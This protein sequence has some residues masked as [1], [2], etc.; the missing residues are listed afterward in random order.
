M[1]LTT[2]KAI[3]IFTLFVLS[4][5]FIIMLDFLKK[6]KVI[7]GAYQ[8]YLKHPARQL[9]GGC[10]VFFLVNSVVVLRTVSGKE[11]CFGSVKKLTETNDG[12]FVIIK[13][14][15]SQAV[16]S[17]KGEFLADFAL[18]S[19][20]F[21]NGWF[22]RVE[23][24]EVLLIDENGHNICSKLSKALVFQDGKY[25]ISVAADGDASKVGFFNADG[26]RIIFTNDHG[27]KCL[28]PYFFIADGSLFTLKGRCLIEANQG[29]N[30]NRKLVSLLGTL[31]IWKH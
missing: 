27:F 25:F 28:F 3:Y 18:Q 11:L 24:G 9:K 1:Y 26:S 5:L 7:D 2:L 20:L 16:F 17:P 6:E 8:G 23:D 22:T 29:R 12:K 15:H 30:F 21:S 4:N 19:R 10:I 13:R 31:P 14:D